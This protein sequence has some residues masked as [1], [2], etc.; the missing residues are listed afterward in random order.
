[1]KKII[2]LFLLFSFNSYACRPTANFIAPN[3]TQNLSKSEFVF[4]GKVVSIKEIGQSSNPFGTKYEIEFEVVKNLKGV[5]GKKIKLLS[6]ANTCDRF[7]QDASVNM[8]CVILADK[9][10]QIISGLLYGEA[11][12]CKSNYMKE[13]ESIFNERLKTLLQKKSL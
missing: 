9:D 1:M 5:S 2:M 11:S 4:S 13:S 12:I 10:N 7:G 3:L 6:F 8:E